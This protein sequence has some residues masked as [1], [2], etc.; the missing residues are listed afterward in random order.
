MRSS[1][2]ACPQQRGTA[3]KSRSDKR[4]GLLTERLVQELGKGRRVVVVLLA[5]V[6]LDESVVVEGLEGLLGEG[7]S[8]QRDD[9]VGEVLSVEA[10]NA[11]HSAPVHSSAR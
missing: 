11:R 3:S 1:V 5:G 10:A 8:V 9:L 7:S 2:N 4:R 6:V